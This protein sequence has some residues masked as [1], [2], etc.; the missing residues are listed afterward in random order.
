[1]ILSFINPSTHPLPLTSLPKPF[2]LSPAVDRFNALSTA[3]AARKIPRLREARPAKVMS[4]ALAASKD[5]ERALDAMIEVTGG[6][7][8]PLAKMADRPANSSGRPTMVC[9]Q[10]APRD[11]GRSPPACQGSPYARGHGTQPIHALSPRPMIR[12]EHQLVTPTCPTMGV[13]TLRKVTV[14]R[15]LLVSLSSRDDNLPLVKHDT[16][17][18]LNPC[19]ARIRYT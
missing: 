10:S 12:K 4:C 1:L 16:L 7:G 15:Q 3:A 18:D 19:G 13:L 9:G 11:E 2:I 14:R 8:M 6:A 17:V 5:L